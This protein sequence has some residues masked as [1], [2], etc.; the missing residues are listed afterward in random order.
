MGTCAVNG[1]NTL[2]EYISFTVKILKFKH[3]GRMVL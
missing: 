3:R 2:F 1:V